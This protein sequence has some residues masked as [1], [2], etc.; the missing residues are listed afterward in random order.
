[1]KIISFDERTTSGVPT[2]RRPPSDPMNIFNPVEDEVVD[3]LVGDDFRATYFAGEAKKVVL[4]VKLMG[5]ARKDTTGRVWEQPHSNTTKRNI[6]NDDGLLL[7]LFFERN[8]YV[9]NEL[10]DW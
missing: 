7:I 4:R 9:T 6:A 10:S 3:L 8:N 1:M 2:P 5:V